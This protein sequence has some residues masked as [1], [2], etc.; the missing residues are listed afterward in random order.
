[1]PKFITHRDFEFIQHI[2]REVVSELVDILVVVYKIIPGETKPNLYG[3]ATEKTRYVGVT[4]P[5]LIKY[6]KTGMTS[7]KYALDSIQNVE[8]RF[9]RRILEEADIRPEAGDIIQYNELYYEVDNTADTQLVGSRPEFA[10]SI[11]CEAHLTRMSG[12]SIEPR[13]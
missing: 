13:Q 9:A 1:M 12:L 11:L 10:L 2:N 3:E 6:D 4:I 7:S 8:F 5:C